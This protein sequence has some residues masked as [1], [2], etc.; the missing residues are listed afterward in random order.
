MN[1]DQDNIRDDG[2]RYRT[3][4][5]GSMFAPT[6]GATMSCIRC[7]VHRYRTSLKAT[8]L[9]GVTHYRCVDGCVQR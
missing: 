5:V 9:A 4:A 7:G 3:K 8:K 6:S 2:L 1:Q